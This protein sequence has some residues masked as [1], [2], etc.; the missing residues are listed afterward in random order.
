M[1]SPLRGVEMSAPEPQ[2]AVDS[3]GGSASEARYPTM[4]AFARDVRDAFAEV[5][6]VDLQPDQLAAADPGVEQEQQDLR[7]AA[8]G[9]VSR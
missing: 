7:V 6:I 2:I 5:E 3:D 1:L 4:P 9:E 8:I